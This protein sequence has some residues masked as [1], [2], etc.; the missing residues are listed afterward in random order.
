M[1]TRA[2]TQR[3]DHDRLLRRLDWSPEV[4]PSGRP[5]D[6][7]IVPASRR[8]NR[9]SAVIDLASRCETTLVILASHQCDIDEV[10]ALIAKRPGKARAVLA[11]VPLQTDHEALRLVTSAEDIRALSGDRSSNLSLK[12]NIG[13]LLARYRGWQKIM[14]LDD[15]IIRITPEQVARV[16]HHL[17]SNRFAGFKTVDFPD[18]SVVCHANRLVDRPQGIFVSGAA[19]GVNTAGHR[20]LEVFPDIYNEDWFAFAGEAETN[21]VAHVGD[22]GQ[23]SFNPFKDSGRATFEEFGD[24]I[25]E[26]L[27]TLFT[28]G[29]GLHRATTD[30]WRQFI[31]ERW[32]LI[33]EIRRKLD[34]NATHEAVQA[35]KSLQAAQC[36]LEITNADDCVR[37]LDVWQEDQR[38]FGKA[39]RLAFGRDYDYRE[40]FDA[41]GLYRWQEARFGIERL[42]VSAGW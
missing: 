2:G 36:Q 4:R 28:D 25:A 5:L 1:S 34:E 29:G 38:R 3:S 35:A 7:I 17:D 26:G 18:N 13:L 32:A 39:S 15:D 10:A 33:S 27:Y 31:D 41:L 24:L 40:A 14:F 11:E 42:P 19:L 6:A 23:L 8:A 21:G 12:R 20:P 30:F 9:L 16:A 22:V 37:F